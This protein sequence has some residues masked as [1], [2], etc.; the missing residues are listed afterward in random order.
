MKTQPSLASQIRQALPLSLGMLLLVGSTVQAGP[1]QGGFSLP[2]PGGGAGGPGTPF[3]MP[4]GGAPG[5]SLPFKPQGG[6][7]AGMGSPLKPTTIPGGL[8]FMKTL[9]GGAGAIRIP[10]GPLGLPGGPLSTNGD[11]GKHPGRQGQQGQQGQPRG[12]GV[13]VAIASQVLQGLISQLGSG[14]FAGGGGGGGGYD[15]GS[16]G[17]GDICPV[18]S[19]IV[20]VEAQ[21]LASP[22]SST[23]TQ[24]QGNTTA[25]QITELVRGPAARAGLQKGDILLRV[26]GQRVRTVADL[27]ATLSASRG[28]STIQFVN[29]DDGKIESRDLSVIGGKIGV[30]VV[31]IPVQLDESEPAPAATPA[32]PATPAASETPAGETALQVTEVRAGNALDAGIQ[33]KDV[34]LY[35]D[36]RKVATADDL[37]AAFKASKGESEIELYTPAI[38]KGKT[39]TMKVEPGKI[40]L[41][42]K[43]VPIEIR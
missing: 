20:P 15:P 9:P 5:L 38:G 34:I 23:V 14:G 16:F 40:G 26:D 24:A 41:G 10:K 36:G 27:V 4:G 17:G 2:R 35:V 7:F 28:T 29:S 37:V 3:K 30:A 19:G 12:N 33:V 31:E 25:L 39:L 13:G 6:G 1:P 8:P 21:Q 11:P 18:P 42:V 32:P 43:V 22:E